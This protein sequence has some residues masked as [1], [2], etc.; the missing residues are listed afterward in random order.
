MDG[1]VIV[2]PLPPPVGAD[3]G[4]ATGADTGEPVQYSGPDPQYPH[5]EQ[6][7]PPEQIPFPRFP[8]PQ[9]APPPEELT[10][11]LTGAVGVGAG[12]VGVGAGPVLPPQPVQVT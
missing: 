11:A 10:G 2:Y 5:C 6:H 12:A 3:T 7:N 9:V 8:L 4:A 1:E